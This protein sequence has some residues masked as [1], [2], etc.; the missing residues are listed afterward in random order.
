M[1]TFLR[2]LIVIAITMI[3]AIVYERYSTQQEFGSSTRLAIFLLVCF[4]LSL[5]ITLLSLKTRFHRA[6]TQLWLTTISV[7][8]TFV[9]ADLIAGAFLVESLSP[10]LSTDKIRHH[11][12]VPNT[13][14]KFEQPDFS[15]TQSV[16]NL[17]LR[18]KDR[19]VEKPSQ[20]FRVIL[21]GDSFTMG[22]GV[23][24]QQ[25]FAALLE[26]SLNQRSGCES[27][28]IEV[29]NGGVDSY[30]PILSYLQLSGD[31]APLDPDIILL[32]LDVSDL[33]QEAAYRK[34]A[35]Y[36][37]SGEIT[38]V[39]GSELPPTLKQRIRAWLDQHTYFTR[40]LLFY[41]DKLFGDKDLTVQGVVARANPEL[42]RYT[43]A[44]DKINRDEQWALIFDSIAKIKQ[45]AD[46]RSI[47]FALVIYPWGHQ[48]NDRE[49]IPGRY[50][51]VSEGATVSD[52][53][54]E[55]IYRQSQ[56]YGIELVD[57]FA[58]F[59]AYKGEAPLYFKYDLHW[60]SEGHKVMAAGLEQYLVKN[61][62][63]KW[64]KSGA[65]SA[66]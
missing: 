24:D 11:K 19:P 35:S 62:S 13:R 5:A 65:N 44:E 21:L 4:A 23:T 17:G 52:K 54:L 15:Y 60:T 34:I 66:K 50:N 36:D 61:H 57:L 3:A 33:L 7:G 30:A 8:L 6:V 47:A 59:R 45:F 43:L 1:K 64:C 29:L 10:A 16:N 56:K 28:E 53:Y 40:L 12:L 37:S 14:S 26:A 2:T 27:T 55:T 38:G 58:T 46:Q 39:P 41:T 31:L 51:F 20:H 9:I 25:T 63:A 42:V 18:G 48:V 22:K 49:W 32:N